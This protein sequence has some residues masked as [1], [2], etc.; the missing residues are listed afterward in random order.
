[1]IFREQKSHQTG[2]PVSEKEVH[3]IL[4]IHSPK[5]RCI[6]SACSV[7]AEGNGRSSSQMPLLACVIPLHQTKVIASMCALNIVCILQ[8]ML[9]HYEGQMSFA[10]HDLCSAIFKIL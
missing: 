3:Q 2:I 8:A 10:V 4:I 5:S 6:V 1:M 9:V 7:A